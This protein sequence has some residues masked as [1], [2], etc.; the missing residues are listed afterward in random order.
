MK[1]KIFLPLIILALF[2]LG[3]T[4]TI[5]I[6]KLVRDTVWL[7]RPSLAPTFITI[8][9]TVTETKTDTV[10]IQT[11]ITKTDTLLLVVTRDSIVYQIQEK[12]VA[13]YDTIIIVE[14]DTIFQTLYDTVTVVEYQQRVVYLDY[15][16]LFPGQSVTFIPD[17]LM[18]Y[19]QQFIQEAQSRGIN[20]EGGDVIFSYVDPKDLPGEGWH[21]NYVQISG[22]QN[23]IQIS[24]ALIAEKS[25]A[26]VFREM[27]RW[28]LKKQY[29]LDVNKIMS[30]FFRTSPEPT[31]AEINIL[32]Q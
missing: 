3:C 15:Q 21:S 13:T 22:W 17:G 26:C 8:R 6:E 19:Y 1:T 16:Y 27:S 24:S 31:T 20:L 7:Q 23:V 28:Q 18:P 9:D 25:K 2:F 4:E 5:E 10:E 32:M 29:S 30:N 11:V 12:E 14:R